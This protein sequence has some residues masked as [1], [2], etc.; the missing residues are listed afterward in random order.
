MKQKRNGKNITLIP[1]KK[2]G[3][4]WTR[5]DLT[6]YYKTYSKLNIENTGVYRKRQWKS[7]ERAVKNSVNKM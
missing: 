1:N 5:N 7:S 3:G 2:G 6:T 4:G